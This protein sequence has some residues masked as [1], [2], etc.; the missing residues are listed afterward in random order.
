MRR[1]RRNHTAAFKAKVAIAALKGDENL[2]TLADRFE[3]NHWFISFHA[4]VCGDE[5][6]MGATTR[7][8]F[9]RVSCRAACGRW[10]SRLPATIYYADESES[11]F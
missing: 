4:P 6:T 1:P 7:T 11:A 8:L 10:Q 5:Q 3:Q 2:V 9:L